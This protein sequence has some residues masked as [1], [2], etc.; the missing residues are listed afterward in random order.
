MCTRV[1]FFPHTSPKAQQSVRDMRMWRME[2]REWSLH[3]WQLVLL[4]VG[5]ASRYLGASIMHKVMWRCGGKSIGQPG[6]GSWVYIIRK[7]LGCARWLLR[8]RWLSP[9][10]VVPNSYVK[11]AHA[12]GSFLIP[13]VQ[14]PKSLPRALCAVVRA[15]DRAL[16]YGLVF[17]PIIRGDM[18]R[19]RER[20]R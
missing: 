4:I 10:R 1:Y 15:L 17:G 8:P 3:S 12:R 18:E 13:A 19:W 6:P 2:F 5:T 16:F 14:V 20:E 7:R 9:L 11:T